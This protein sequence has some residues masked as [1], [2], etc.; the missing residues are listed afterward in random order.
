MKTRIVFMGTPQI[1]AAILEA[2][3]R[4]PYEV[5]VVYT[6]PDR[7]SGR[8]R[9]LT[10]SPV[11]ELAMKYQIPI[12]QPETL[13]STEVVRGL[14]NFKADLI[15]VA[16]FGQILPREVLSLPKLGCLNVHPSLLPRH[17]GPSPVAE[18]LLC[19]EPFTGVTIMVMDEGIDS[20]PIL[21]QS[22]VAISSVDTT[23]SLMA[24]LAHAGAELL[25]E[26]LP[27]WLA[28]ELEAE[29]QDETQV[30]YSRLISSENGELDWNLPAI[31]LWRQV[32]AFTPWPGCYSWWRGKRLKIH[33]AA[34]LNKPAI[35]IIGEVIALREAPKVGVVTGNGVLGLCQIQMEGKRKML[36]T[37]FVR[38]QG[39]F[40]GSVLGRESV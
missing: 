26:I 20:G 40:V 30:T 2:L 11:K 10:I 29:P 14:A 24:K 1:A 36:V 17:R 13:K 28:G 5:V 31:E 38:G 21:A 23:G 6:Q 15:I 39:S 18:A 37:D 9:Q 25:M 7:P 3:I 12:V 27:K 16:A 8:R 22:R 33:E 34:L 4:S 32:K 35:G 19:G